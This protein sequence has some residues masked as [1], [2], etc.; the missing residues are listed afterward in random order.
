[1]IE[2]LNQHKPYMRKFTKANLIDTDKIEY[3]RL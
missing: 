1:M 2:E 3:P